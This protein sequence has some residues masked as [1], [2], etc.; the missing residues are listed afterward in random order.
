MAQD[1]LDHHFKTEDLEVHGECEQA[2]CKRNQPTKKYLGMSCLPDTLVVVLKRY[3]CMMFQQYDPVLRKQVDVP[4][5]MKVSR[6]AACF[7]RSFPHEQSAIIGIARA[8]CLLIQT[9]SISL[10][11]GHAVLRSHSVSG[12]AAFHIYHIRASSTTADRLTAALNCRGTQQFPAQLCWTWLPTPAL[13]PSPPI[14]HCTM[15]WLML[16]TKASRQPLVTILRPQD[17]RLTTVNGQLTMTM[18]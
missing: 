7:E 5:S 1:C 13:A 8:L 15:L 14:Q 6:H 4:E 3:E 10:H 18:S 12:L 16:A 11:G 17:A 2:C 9:N